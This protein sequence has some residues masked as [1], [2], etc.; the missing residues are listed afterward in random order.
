MLYV[1]VGDHTIASALTQEFEGKERVI[2]YLT[3]RLSDPET[4]YSPI[5]KICLCLLFMY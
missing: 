1:A 5:E 2:F 4:R 3:R